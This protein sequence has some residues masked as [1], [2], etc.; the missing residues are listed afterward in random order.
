MVFVPKIYIS[1]HHLFI[2][3][4]CKKFIL[5]EAA[6][7][8]AEH[9]HIIYFFKQ[10]RIIILYILLSK[11]CLKLCHINLLTFFKKYLKINS[12]LLSFSISNKLLILSF[13]NS[14]CLEENYKFI[15]SIGSLFFCWFINWDFSKTSR[16]TSS[17]ERLLASSDKGIWETLGAAFFTEGRTY[18]LPKFNDSWS[19]FFLLLIWFD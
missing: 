11:V 5:I 10:S 17:W 2:K 1:F 6:G 14:L 12:Y 13:I 4:K 19:L 18:W 15:S 8:F 7:E 3:K 16:S 9:G